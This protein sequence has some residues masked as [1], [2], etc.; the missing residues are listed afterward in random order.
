MSIHSIHPG[1]LERYRKRAKL[2]QQGLADFARISLKTIARIEG[3]KNKANS[4][5]VN[6]LAKALDVKPEDLA[7]PFREQ[8]PK[9]Y[10]HGFQTRR[11]PFKENTLVA[12]KM[13]EER[14]GISL[15]DQLNMA[16]LLVALMAEGSLAWRQKQLDMAKEAVGT[17]WIKSSEANGAMDVEEESLMKRDIFGKQ[18]IQ[19]AE[20]IGFD[21]GSSPFVKYLC[22]FAIETGSEFIKVMPDP[23]EGDQEFA[24]IEYDCWMTSINLPQTFVCYSLNAAE[25]DRLTGNNERAMRALQWDHVQ[26]ADIPE[27][28]LGEDKDE[29]R[30]NWL[31]DK[32]PQAKWDE[33]E[34]YWSE[35]KKVFDRDAGENKNEDG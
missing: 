19:H 24:E 8:E 28:L 3:G 27:E 14:Y 10:L 11:V 31:G 1:T 15:M 29:E 5:T 20:E 30:S 23:G 25:L 35:V 34:A 16:P 17:L 7:K 26:M 4:H 22:N 21:P 9:P 18:P 33:H 6:S 32:I 2:T 12:L 13:N